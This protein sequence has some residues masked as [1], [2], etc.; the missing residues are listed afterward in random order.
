MDGVRKEA[1]MKPTKK[2][3][4]LAAIHR[5]GKSGTVTQYTLASGVLFGILKI[6]VLFTCLPLCTPS[7]AGDAGVPVRV[8][9]R[10]CFYNNIIVIVY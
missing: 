10:L 4:I 2:I 8:H 5:N 9:L 3:F 1:K 7:A 6:S